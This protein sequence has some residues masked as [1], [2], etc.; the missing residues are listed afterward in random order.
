MSG[1]CLESECLESV[2]SVWRVSV[3]SECLESVWRVSVWR[4]SGE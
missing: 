2:W 3:E 1:E 4:V